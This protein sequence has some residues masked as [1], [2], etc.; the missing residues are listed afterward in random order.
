VPV[1]AL[2]ELDAEEYAVFVVENGVP[3]LRTVEVGLMDLTYAEILSG[4]KSG[5]TVSTGMV[6]TQS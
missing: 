2:R 1:E 5:E 3:K 4:V 6:E